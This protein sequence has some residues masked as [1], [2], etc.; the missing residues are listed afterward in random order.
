MENFCNVTVSLS[1][2][3]HKAQKARAGVYSKF[4]LRGG[5]SRGPIDFT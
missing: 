4:Q 2:L 1:K 5:V 3:G